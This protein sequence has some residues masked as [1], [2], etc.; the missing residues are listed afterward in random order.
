MD[1]LTLVAIVVVI[2]ACTEL[3]TKSKIFLPIRELLKDRAFTGELIGCPYCVSVWVA[4]GVVYPYLY[5]P[6]A[7]T[8]PIGLVFLTHRLSNFVHHLYEMTFWSSFVL[9]RKSNE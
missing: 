1:I 7:I 5:L 4:L 6:S 9:E 2:E 3:I 8:V